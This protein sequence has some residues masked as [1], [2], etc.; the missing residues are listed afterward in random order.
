MSHDNLT[1]TA[2]IADSYLGVTDRDSFISYLP[3]SHSAAQMIDVWMPLAARASV[4][5]ADRNALKG[6]LVDTLREVR[7]TFFFGV[8]RIYEK[9]QEKVGN[10][11]D[12]AVDL[13][14]FILM[15]VV[16]R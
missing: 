4:Y 13:K 9:I 6:S 1:W 12:V 11:N 2:R 10:R 15:T 16:L 14:T 8:P 5:F 3:L 7:P